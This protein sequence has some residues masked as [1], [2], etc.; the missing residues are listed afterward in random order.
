[1]K[2]AQYKLALAFGYPNPELLLNQ[3]TQT[4]FI[5]WQTYLSIYPTGFEADNLLMANLLSFIYHALKSKDDKEATLSDFMLTLQEQNQ[6][7]EWEKS[8]EQVK[9]IVSILNK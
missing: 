7:P 3:I 1:M 4:Q 8:L 5:E 9:N 2:Q 6:E